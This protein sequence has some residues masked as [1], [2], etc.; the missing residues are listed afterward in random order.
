MLHRTIAAVAEMFYL[1]EGKMSVCL[2]EQSQYNV[3]DRIFISP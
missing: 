1:T 2:P 3:Q